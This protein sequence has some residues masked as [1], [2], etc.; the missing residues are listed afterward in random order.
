MAIS[1]ATRNRLSNG[2]KA[3]DDGGLRP[4]S[5]NQRALD[6][7]YYRLDLDSAF[8]VDDGVQIIFEAFCEQKKVIAD[9]NGNP[10][11]DK[12]HQEGFW[13]Y[14]N[15]QLGTRFL[16]TTD[17]AVVAP[18]EPAAFEYETTTGRVKQ[19]FLP[20]DDW[21]S[22]LRDAAQAK[23]LTG[24]P[25]ACSYPNRGFLQYACDDRTGHQLGAR[26][27][28][29][30]VAAVIIESVGAL[31]GAVQQYELRVFAELARQ[32]ARTQCLM[33]IVLCA[34]TFTSAGPWQLHV[35]DE[36]TRDTLAR[37]DLPR[38]PPRP[39]ERLD[40]PAVRRWRHIWDTELQMHER[41]RILRDQAKHRS[42]KEDGAAHCPNCLQGSCNPGDVRSHKLVP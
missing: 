30:G 26:I 34:H 19:V 8:G 13:L 12:P 32:L 39:W 3:P 16:K 9:L 36:A 1:L 38:L 20:H 28:N 22:D 42:L 18:T 27:R 5:I 41:H 29:Y 17:K 31:D 37:Y 7:A 14:L 25:F 11:N 21:R 2:V 23:L 24:Q 35:I 10:V 33:P 40:H 6:V 15:R 4:F